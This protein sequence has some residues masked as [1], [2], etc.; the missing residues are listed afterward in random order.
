MKITDAELN[1]LSILDVHRGK[2]PQGKRECRCRHSD[3]FVLVSSGSADY[4]FDGKVYTAKA[5]DLIFLAD[6]S[7]YSIN[8]NCNNYT[9]TYIDFYFDV[10]KS[11][12]LSNMIYKAERLSELENVFEKIYKLWKIGDYADKLYCKALLYTI[13]SKVAKSD[14]IQYVSSKRRKEIEQAAKYMSEHLSDAEISVTQL[15]KL[16]NVSEV[17]FR[18]LF[19]CI[20]HTSPTKFLTALRIKKA[21]ELLTTDNYSIAQISEMCGFQNHYYFS[22]VFK[23]L[24]S[25]TP[26]EYRNRY[27]EL[28]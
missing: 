15:G 17:H 2:I 9:Y 12:T 19:N 20:Y 14:L 26:T 24:T 27:R 16:C 5:G 22:K 8:I 25:L 7:C 1:I 21:K 11:A 18:R 10:E 13:Y 6:H 28:I 3:S 23:S 4:S